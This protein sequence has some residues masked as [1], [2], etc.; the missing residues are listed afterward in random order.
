MLERKR[1]LYEKIAFLEAENQR[2]AGCLA[3]IRRT[4]EEAA[5]K[6][7]REWEDFWAYDGNVQEQE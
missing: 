4:E 6:S 5:E 7:R 3:A 1:T 2:L